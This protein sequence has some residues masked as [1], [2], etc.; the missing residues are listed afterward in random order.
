MAYRVKCP[1]RKNM[2]VKSNPIKLQNWKENQWMQWLNECHPD[3]K[4]DISW[5]R[6]ELMTCIEAEWGTIIQDQVDHSK[7]LEDLM[8][9]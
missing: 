6:I 5:L 2:K 4:T 3:K 1:N 7:T 8:E 9:S